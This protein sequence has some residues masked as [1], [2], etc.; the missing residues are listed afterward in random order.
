MIQTEK[1][2]FVEFTDPAHI[3]C[4]KLLKSLLSVGLGE[5]QRII[6]H[7]MKEMLLINA[8]KI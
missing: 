8:S 5:V 1:F 3:L 4:T 2:Q 6:S 7:T